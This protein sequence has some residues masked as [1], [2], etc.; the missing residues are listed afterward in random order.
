MAAAFADERIRPGE[1]FRVQHA[2]NTSTGPIVDRAPEPSGLFHSVCSGE[3]A[4]DALHKTISELEKRLENVVVS[5]PNKAAEP[6]GAIGP[7]VPVS[8]ASGRVR[9]I[10]HGI[11]MATSRLAALARGLDL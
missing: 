6:S 5:D 9:S 1:V 7:A 3:D 4:L 11:H 8:M 10:A 2:S